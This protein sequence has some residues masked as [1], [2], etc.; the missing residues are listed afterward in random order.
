[1]LLHGLATLKAYSNSDIYHFCL[2]IVGGIHYGS[3]DDGYVSLIS[4]THNVL[5]S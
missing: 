5:S 1:M 2:Q 3:L 4:M